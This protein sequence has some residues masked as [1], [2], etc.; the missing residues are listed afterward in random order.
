MRLVAWVKTREK[1]IAP[2][3]LV[4]AAVLWVAAVVWHVLG[5]G[6]PL[7]SA[8]ALARVYA[9]GLGGKTGEPPEAG[10]L[11]MAGL[12]GK[13]GAVLAAVYAYLKLLDISGDKVLLRFMYRDHVVIVGLGGKTARLARSLKAA[14]RKVAVIELNEGHASA[15]FLRADGVAVLHGDGRAADALQQAGLARAST[16]VC[17][18]DSDAV[19]LQ[20]A[21]TA[22]ELVGAGGRGSPLRCLVHVADHSLRQIASEAPHYRRQDARFDGHVL[23]VV[24]VAA[25]ALLA[26]W[27]PDRLASLHAPDA[28]RLHVLVVGAEDLARAIVVNL[29]LQA[30]YA[31]PQRPVVSLLDPG[32]SQA[33]VRLTAEY[34]ALTTLIELRAEDVALQHLSPAQLLERTGQ[35]LEGGGPL[36][37]LT[38]VCVTIARDIDALAA[39]LHLA[40]LT[41][42]GPQRP[43]IV[44]CVP[45][46]SDVMSCVGVENTGDALGFATFDRY[47]ICSA[48]T[49][50]GESLDRVARERH[51]AYLEKIQASGKPLRTKPTQFPWDELDDMVKAFNRRRWSTAAGWPTS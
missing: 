31:T 51:D 10:L 5:A 14:G 29:A 27:A 4:S 39:G 50:L 9:F 11:A 2:A 3:L 45:P 16:L 17:L 40:R 23:D 26:E 1:M 7:W 42:S 12:L 41:R 32:A 38:L 47:S 33:L 43:Q 35:R 28:P 6:V 13:S 19:N 48:Q 22:R 49:L 21:R 30:H 20:V 37:P 15:P 36:P 34:P 8:E 46:D 25:R 44:V 18:T 24:D